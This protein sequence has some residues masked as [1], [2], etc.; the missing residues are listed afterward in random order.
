LKTD[1][2]ELGSFIVTEDDLEEYVLCIASC[3][4][5]VYSIFCMNVVM[6]WRCLCDVNE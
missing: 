3:S 1:I 6:V 2:F 5:N 4:K